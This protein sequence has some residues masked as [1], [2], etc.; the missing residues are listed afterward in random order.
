[1]SVMVSVSKRCTQSDQLLR[2][3]CGHRSEYALHSGFFIYLFF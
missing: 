1:M 3:D 2:T